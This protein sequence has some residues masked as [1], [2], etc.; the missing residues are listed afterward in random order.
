MGKYQQWQWSEKKMP[1][2][3]C[4]SD[5]SSRD[6]AKKLMSG[7]YEWETFS[8]LTGYTWGKCLCNGLIQQFLPGP[9]VTGGWNDPDP[10]TII[11]GIHLFH[12]YGLCLGCIFVANPKGNRCRQTSLQ[13]T[14][15][16]CLYSPRLNING[17]SKGSLVISLH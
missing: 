5:K 11:D 16:L 6:V 2:S 17:G 15:V 7:G 12:L 14:F 13:S 8:V 1:P 10:P 3:L 9:S 4:S